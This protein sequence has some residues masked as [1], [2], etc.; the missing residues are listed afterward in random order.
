MPHREFD[1]SI[2]NKIYNKILRRNIPIPSLVLY[3]ENLISLNL[4]VENAFND[5]IRKKEVGIHFFKYLINLS[6]FIFQFKNDS[7]RLYNYLKINLRIRYKQN[8]TRL[9]VQSLP[10][11]VFTIS[12]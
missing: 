10:H 1:D 4:F 2:N 5:L 6:L 3:V 12:N 11:N 8:F 7:N 9:N